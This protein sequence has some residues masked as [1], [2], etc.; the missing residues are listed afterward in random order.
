MAN[1]RPAP[2]W[3]TGG[4]TLFV[5]FVAALGGVL[6]LSRQATYGVGLEWDAINYLAVAQ[7]LLEG[8][9]FVNHDG[10]PN[11]FWPPLYPTLLAIASLGV[12]DPLD[13]AGPLN[14]ALFAALIFV[15]GSYLRRTLN[16][17]FAVAWGSFAVALAI[18]LA[19]VANWAMSDTLFLLLATLALTQAHRYLA[20]GRAVCL[21][22]AAVFCALAWLTRNIGAAVVAAVGLLMLFGG[23]GP[24]RRRTRHLALF[25]LIAG[26]PTALWLVRNHLLIGTLTGSQAPVHYAW[27]D[28]L[29]E[30]GEVLDGWMRFAPPE[31]WQPPDALLRVGIFALALLAATAVPVGC[32]FAGAQW[33]G[34]AA[35]DWRPVMVFGVFAVA[36]GILLTSSLLLGIAH[37]G[38]QPRYMAPVYVSLVVIG[39]FL[40]DRF[41]VWE[42]EG[43]FF[44]TFA[45]LPGVG[46]GL[47]SSR[48]GAA[49]PVASVAVAAGVLTLA[50]QMASNLQEARRANAP[51]FVPANGYHAQPWA[52]SAILRYLREHPLSGLVYSNISV[53]AWL[54]GDD[55][56]VRKLPGSRLPGNIVS[57]A[58]VTDG[59]RML[60]DWLARAP[61]GA[62]VLWFNNWWTNRLYDYGVADMRVAPGLAPVADLGD[63]TLFRV[64]KGYMPSANPYDL[65]YQYV[66]E[67][68]QA[69]AARDFFDVYLAPG[70]LTYIKAPCA[71][72]DLNARFFL[73]IYPVSEQDLPP[74]Y[75]PFGF[76]N[77][78]FHFPEY[79]TR[80]E[81]R[82]VGVRPL[83]R[84]E[85]S[86]IFTGQYIP[87]WGE[88]WRVGI[89]AAEWLGMP[90]RS[91]GGGG[92]VRFDG[93]G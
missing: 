87:G 75:Q 13:V 83:P 53:L 79:G 68:D 78:D 57:P 7:H 67:S 51:D 3:P 35:V 66:T 85:V 30:V 28:F 37:H 76:D 21:I 89:Q 61:E 47:R 17:R 45:S 22:W 10:S 5:L 55:A 6:V 40:L 70:Q 49:S 19:D 23:H 81:D 36:Y 41:L 52:S 14:A 25:G 9:G 86:R 32:A 42:S 43:H 18:P 1:P 34:R 11:T 82:C 58:S 39:A 65:A 88:R 20:E 4:F 48:L 33:R 64:D 69:P 26:A 50:A 60:R 2:R 24:M 73:H 31:T 27:A 12:L 71:P 80:I 15:V 91:G 62:H 29:R 84:Y 16:T 93:R 74:A 72:D 56:A 46:N 59:Q 54:H 44:G 77:L 92:G 38:V 8:Q 90:P 63:G